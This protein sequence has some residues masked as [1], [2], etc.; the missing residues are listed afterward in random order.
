MARA[1]PVGSPRAG[2]L[3]SQSVSAP[4]P[5]GCIF[6]R[7]RATLLTHHRAIHPQGLYCMV[8]SG[9]AFGGGPRILAFLAIS[10]VMLMPRVYGRRLRN[11]AP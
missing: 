2:L 5:P 1:G 9:L 8:D 11:W 4:S 3:A 7:L 10:S 6:Q